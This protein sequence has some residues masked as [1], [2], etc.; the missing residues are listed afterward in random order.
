MDNVELEAESVEEISK[1]LT[2]DNSQPFLAKLTSSQAGGFIRLRGTLKDKISSL[3]KGYY[4]VDA[5]QWYYF[6]PED[7]IYDSKEENFEIKI[8]ENS[9]DK[10]KEEFI[11]LIRVYDARENQANIRIKI[12]RKGQ[13]LHAE[14]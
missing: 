12:N 13:I 6:L 1:T 4:S 7:Q 2:V 8:A 11:V 9:L 10:D 14:I 3:S 5:K